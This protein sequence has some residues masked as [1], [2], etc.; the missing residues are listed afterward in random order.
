M[1]LQT[2]KMKRLRAILSE[3]YGEENIVSLREMVEKVSKISKI[4]VRVCNDTNYDEITLKGVDGDGIVKIIT[5]T[6]HKPANSSALERQRLHKGDLV[7]N[8]RG[9]IATVGL[10]NHEHDKPLVGNHGMMKIT[11][12][13]ERKE[14]T[15]KYVQT[16]LQ[17]NLIKTFLFSVMEN[18]TLSTELIYSLPIPKFEEIGGFSAFTTLV[19][20]RQ[21]ITKKLEELLAQSQQRES[22]ILL[23]HKNSLDKLSDVNAKDNA[24]IAEL[25][26]LYT[27]MELFTPKESNFYSHSFDDLYK[28]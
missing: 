21:E 25:K 2:N 12:A 20:R 27:K 15:P 11:F 24:I 8:Y 18:N 26:S 10:I 13:Q 17:T 4:H 22:E 3:H 6:E 28:G 5:D 7:F 23:I 1:V 9:K 16:Y 14:D 19:T